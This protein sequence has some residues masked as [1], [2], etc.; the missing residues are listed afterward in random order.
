MNFLGTSQG[1][2]SS[3]MASIWK[4]TGSS[5]ELQ[6]NPTVCWNRNFCKYLSF[7]KLRWWHSR[8]PLPVFQ[9]FLLSEL[10]RSTATGLPAP[11]HKPENAGDSR[12][13]KLKKKKLFSLRVW[14]I[15]Q[16][17]CTFGLFCIFF[18]SFACKW[19]EMSESPNQ[20]MYLYRKSCPSQ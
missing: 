19:S 11:K 15:S 12:E 13:E 10:P 18:S 6:G 16:S 8:R 9:S 7:E 1:F 14:K 3:K 17:G 5:P 2:P 20:Y 4:E